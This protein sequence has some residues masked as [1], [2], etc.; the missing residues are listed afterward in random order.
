MVRLLRDIPEHHLAAGTVGVVV[1]VYDEPN[2]PIAY[3]VDF[4]NVKEKELK[5][6]TLYEQDIE[7]LK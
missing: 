1:I 7:S 6:L 5:T 2:L 4:S 3:E